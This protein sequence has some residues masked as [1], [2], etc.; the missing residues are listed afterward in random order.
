MSKIRKFFGLE[1]N[2]FLWQLIAAGVLLVADTALIVVII[3][4]L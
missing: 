3:A 4:R 1:V 2:V